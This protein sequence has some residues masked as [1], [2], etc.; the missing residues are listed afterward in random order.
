MMIK[1]NKAKHRILT[2]DEHPI[3]RDGIKNLIET[4]GRMQVCGQTGD[5]CEVMDLMFRLKP[6]AIICGLS[7]ENGDGISLINQINARHS[8]TPILVF[9][10][11]DESTHALRCIKAGA[12]GYLMKKSPSMEIIYALQE[13]L[14]GNIYV[15]ETI[16]KQIIN[17]FTV[18]VINGMNSIDTLS[19][20]EF[21]IYRL[22]GQGLQTV[23][24][25]D[26]IKCSSK[27]IETHCLRIRRKMML[28]NIN[29]LISSASK[30]FAGVLCSSMEESVP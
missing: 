29:E 21:Q 24:I 30:Y 17:S 26:K 18:P 4:D 6:H 22:Y 16:K 5:Y 12:R 9:S 25:A 11:Y 8:G 28:H 2:V 3:V 15:S 14:K 27:T 23:Q 19:P 13:I 7:V 1:E 20:R 10:M